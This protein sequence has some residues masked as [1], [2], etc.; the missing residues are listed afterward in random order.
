MSEFSCRF[1]ELILYV[2]DME[3]EVRFYGVPITS[4]FDPDG[5][6]FSIRE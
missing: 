2:R 5:H 3:N 4:G 1:S 6:G